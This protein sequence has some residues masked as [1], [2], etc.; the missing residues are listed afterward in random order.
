MRVIT[1]FALLVA[2][3]C[4]AQDVAPPA[5]NQ[6]NVFHVSVQVV[7]LDALVENKKTHALIG[8]LGRSDFQLAEDGVPQP[9]TF[10]DHDQL[11][12][13]IVFIFDLTDSVRPTLKPLAAG[14]IEV[15]SHLK[16][17]DEA[18]VMVFA[19]HAKLLQEYTTDHAL[20][21]KGHR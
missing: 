16:P 19:K 5:P 12:L 4:L 1:I 14:A 10:F 9:I 6:D 8:G 13:S 3:S 21:A 7:T 18:A 17:T 11:P 15:L 2:S 20:I